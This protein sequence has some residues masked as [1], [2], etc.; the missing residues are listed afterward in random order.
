LSGAKPRVH[1]WRRGDARPRRGNDAPRNDVA[2]AY[3]PFVP[4]SCRSIKL[5]NY[6]SFETATL[7]P[8][9]LTAIVGANSAGKSNLIDAFR[10]VS[11]ALTPGVGLPVALERRGGFERVVHQTTQSGG[12]RR[13]VRLTLELDLE[14]EGVQWYSIYLE[15]KKGGYQ[16]KEEVL[17]R[18]EQLSNCIF[19]VRGGAIAVVPAGLAP[20]W[21]SERLTLPLVASHPDIEPA[22]DFLTRMQACAISTDRLRDYQDP[23]PG[24]RLEPDGRNAAYVLADLRDADVA[25]LVEVLGKV[26]PGIT[27]V[28]SA[29]RGTKRT[30]VFTK[31]VHSDRAIDFEALQM[32]EGTLRLFGVLVALFQPHRP[33]VLTIEEP[34]AGLHFA[35]AQAMVETFQEL[36]G[37]VQLLFTT[38]DP[39][40]ID[41]TNAQEVRVVRDDGGASV[42]APLAQHTLATIRD[43]LISPGE[44]LRR[45]ALHAQDQPVAASTSG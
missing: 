11:E 16:V 17:A 20:P 36:A 22:F 3:A 29:R 34:E 1:E 35:A 8:D 45:G 10:F 39:D 43:E 23:D 40:L 12:R 14:D 28:R 5:E 31:K 41:V 2:V 27:G 26:V 25:E 4:P 7:R 21:A 13:N 38:H 42:V 24:D 32:S 33:T 15:A 19:A 18:D 37:E 9:R 6:R 30:I 44:L